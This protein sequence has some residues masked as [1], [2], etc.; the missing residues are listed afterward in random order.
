MID[1]NSEDDEFEVTDKGSDADDD[2]F[3]DPEMLAL[4]L[5]FLVEDALKNPEKLVP[6]T[7]EMHQEAMALIEGVVLDEDD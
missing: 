3:E 6:Y 5:D 2:E 1:E 4:F 7:E